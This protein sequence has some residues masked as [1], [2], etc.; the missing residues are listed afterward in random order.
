MD[1]WDKREF[2]EDELA[3][4]ITNAFENMKNFIDELKNGMKRYSED[5]LNDMK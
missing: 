3:L 1:I 2:E 4:S 5:T